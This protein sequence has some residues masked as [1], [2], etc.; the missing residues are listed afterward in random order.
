MCI[1]DSGTT[2]PSIQV[3]VENTVA[4]SGGKLRLG[5]S[6]SSTSGVMGRLIFGNSND[7]AQSIIEGLSDG[8]T[9]ASALV[10]KT[11]AT[12]SSEAE[13]MRIDSSGNVGI[14]TSSPQAIS[15]FK[16][17][18]VQG[19]TTT[20]G[21]IYYSSSSDSSQKAHYYM[22]NGCLLYTSP[23]PRDGLLSRMPSSA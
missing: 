12:G 9:D 5:T 2:S 20:T 1:R 21:G 22:G 10:F 8:A 11:E 16:T 4:N 23:S 13:R 19:D 17:L 6:D 7:I 14:G 15:N 18:E 3:D